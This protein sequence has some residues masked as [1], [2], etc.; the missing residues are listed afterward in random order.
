MLL[1]IGSAGNL[2]FLLDTLTKEVKSSLDCSFFY[3]FGLF[4]VAILVFRSAKD[5]YFMLDA[6]DQGLK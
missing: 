1:L 5:L 3:I 2:N 4:I 6:P